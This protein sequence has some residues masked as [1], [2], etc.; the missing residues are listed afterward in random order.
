MTVG[1]KI[2]DYP[3]V[4]AAGDGDRCYLVTD[5]TGTPAS[6][7]IAVGNLLRLGH[8]AIYTQ[9]GSGAHAL[10]ADTWTKAIF[11]SDGPDDGSV[12]VA[13]AANDRI[14][15]LVAGTYLVRFGISF[16][17]SGVATAK[18]AIYAGASPAQQYAWASRD[19]ISGATTKAHFMACEAIYT[20]TSPTE[21]FE[22]WV[23]ATAGTNI[24]YQN[25]QLTALRIA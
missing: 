10:T 25:L 12:L 8:A 5:P 15:A 16:L 22:G 19:V 18:C 7:G 17:L 3:V 20:V 2:T 23:L 1:K 11:G 9:A 21:Y 14:Q 13:D 24:V 6:K 4:T